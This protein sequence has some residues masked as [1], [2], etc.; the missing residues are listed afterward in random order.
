MLIR[1]FTKEDVENIKQI[2]SLYSFS[3][4]ELEHV[5]GYLNE[6]LNKSSR[7]LEWDLRYLVAE[8]DNKIIGVLGFRKPPSKL[9]PFVD[10][11]KPIELYSL[12]VGIKQK[13]IGRSLVQKMIEIVKDDKKIRPGYGRHYRNGN[14]TP[15]S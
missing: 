11:D 8:D 13:N 5:S 15:R 7:A 2:Y 10:T 6:A 4:E 9:I 1:Y 12:F 14:P 3:Q